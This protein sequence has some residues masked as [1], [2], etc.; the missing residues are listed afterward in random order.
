M[1]QAWKKLWRD[2][3][4]NALVIAGAA[5]PLIVGSAGLATDTIQW[6]LWKRQLQRTAD[7][8]AIAGVYAQLASQDVTTQVN[9]DVAKNNQTG[10]AL[11]SGPTITFPAN[12]GTW[13][14]S[15]AVGMS[16]KKKLSFSSM[17]MANPP[18]ITVNATAAAVAAGEYCAQ[19]QINTNT[20]GIKAGGSAT[21]DLKCGMITNS[22]SMDAAVAFGSSVVNASP[23]A[24][25][26]GLD[27]TDNWAN[28]TILL[29]FTIPQPDPFKD[30]MPP[31]IPSPCNDQFNDTPQENQTWPDTAPAGGSMCLKN[32]TAQGTV[33]LQPNTTY[34]I[35]GDM[36]IGAQANVTCSGCTFVMTNSNPTNTGTVDIQGG[37]TVN[38]TA[39][40]SGTYKGI[41]FYSDRGADPTDI[42]KINGNSMSNYSGAFYFPHQQV[43]FTGTAGVEFQCLKLVTWQLTFNGTSSIKNNCPPG[44]YGDRFVGRHVRLVA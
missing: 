42:N 15:V 36:K 33:T 8:A 21:V 20:T 13:T 11:L 25:V 10:L 16:V 9:N 1:I 44:W 38:L 23:V 43:E 17:F 35:T 19:A 26:G 6:T 30:I 3:R 14:N 34:I 29:P 31:A 27:K 24:A 28:G 2:R 40:D 32:F 7:S 37:A 39:P 5:L 18:T 22:T 4:G 41:L 12:S